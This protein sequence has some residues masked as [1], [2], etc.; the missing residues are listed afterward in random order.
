MWQSYDQ[1][2]TQLPD[3]VPGAP[4]PIMKLPGPMI[5]VSPPEIRGV[6]SAASARKGCFHAHASPLP[7]PGQDASALPLHGVGSPCLLQTDSTIRI[8][9]A[10]ASSLFYICFG[11]S[12]R[13]HSHVATRVIIALTP[14]ASHKRGENSNNITEVAT[15]I[16]VAHHFAF[17]LTAPVACQS[18]IIGPMIGWA[19]SQSCRR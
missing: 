15:I 16:V 4:R 17:R 14:V 3:V 18:R 9:R 7:L 13:N 5:S 11:G 6:P 12:G 8:A 1:L 2:D 10:P 19:S